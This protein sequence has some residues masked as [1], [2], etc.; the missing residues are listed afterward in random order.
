MRVQGFL[1]YRIWYGNCLVYVGRTKQPLQSRIRGHLFSKPMHR[2]V[3]IEQV[4]KIEYAELGSEADMN[5]YEIYYILRL[6]PPLN[7]DDKARDDLS[8]T[9]SRRLLDGRIA[10]ADNRGGD[11]LG[12][13][14][15]NVPLDLDAADFNTV[16][17]AV[18]E[19]YHGSQRVRDGVGCENQPHPFSFQVAVE[20]GPQI[21]W[22]VQQGGGC[23]KFV[24]TP[25]PHTGGVVEHLTYDLAADSGVGAPLHLDENGKSVLVNE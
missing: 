15:G 2:T 13:V 7:V 10:A 6:H 16:H 19:V 24:G 22:H 5:L 21:V 14:L 11:Q 8:V 18:E 1:I 12:T 20:G 4:T 23:P 17:A 3:N 25:R 9:L